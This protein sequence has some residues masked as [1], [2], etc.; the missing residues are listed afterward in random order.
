[1]FPPSEQLFPFSEHVFSP[2]EQLFPFSELVFPL[3]EQLFPF[4]ELVFPP[5][6]QLFPFSEL[7]FP[8]SEQLFPFSEHV[9][10]LSEQ[11]QV[12]LQSFCF[13]PVPFATRM[14]PCLLVP[15]KSKIGVLTEEDPPNEMG[16]PR[17]SFFTSLRF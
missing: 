1:V 12:C 2:S 10:S 6:E 7:V 15:V 8:P 16:C 17:Q 4:S 5:S 3:S 9:F 14:H 13:C 11:P